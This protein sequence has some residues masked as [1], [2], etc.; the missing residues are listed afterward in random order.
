I[1]GEGNP[2]VLRFLPDRPCGPREVA[3]AKSADGNPDKTGPQ[4][5]FPKHRRPASRTEMVS[6]LSA[7][8]S[9][10]Y[11]SVVGTLGAKVLLLKIGADA[12]HRTGPPLTLA[13][14]ACD[15]GIGL[16]RCFDL[17]GAASTTRSSRHNVPPSLGSPRVGRCESESDGLTVW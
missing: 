17:Q 9:I 15:D 10:T 6:D 4:I 13:A 2:F 11:I 16:V 8:G 1:V 5:G 12:K 14:M 3:L 7:F